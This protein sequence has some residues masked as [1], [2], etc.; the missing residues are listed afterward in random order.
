[1]FAYSP[2][3]KPERGHIRQNHPFTKPPFYLPVNFQAN[4][5]IAVAGVLTFHLE[6]ARFADPH[7]PSLRMGPSGAPATWR[8]F[9]NLGP[10][11]PSVSQ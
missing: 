6:R 4:L 3:R 5:R 8:T 9:W 10:L 2:E 1:M 11:I 7:S